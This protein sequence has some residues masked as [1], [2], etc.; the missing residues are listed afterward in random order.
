MNI[1]F[2]PYPKL[3]AS[4]KKEVDA[5]MRDTLRGG[6]FILGKEV[7]EF[8]KNFAEYLGVKHVVGLNS[9]TDA[10]LLALH[11]AGVG[12]GDEVITVSHTFIATIQVIKHVGATPI[13]VDIEDDGLMD[14]DLVGAAI[15]EKTKA[16]IPVHLSGDVVESPVIHAH[17]ASHKR[18]HDI[19]VIE[20]AA[21]A[22]GAVYTVQGSLTANKSGTIGDAGCFSFYPAKILGTF[23]DAG[24][25][26]T[27]D[28]AVA[29]E[30]RKLRNH[31]DISKKPLDSV[32]GPYKFGWN[33]RMDN[34]WAAVLN[35]KLPHLEEDIARR[36]VVASM[37]TLGLNDLPLEL[38]VMR[39]G[40]V[41]QDYVI[42]SEMRDELA[43]Y[44]KDK[45]IGILGHDL[46]PNHKYPGLGL[47][48]FH[49][50]KTEQYIA[51]QIRIP[52]NQFMK[53]KE[54]EY[55]IKTI[56]RFHGM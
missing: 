25:L 18:T 36:H 9:G 23:G 37:Y 24:A 17:L 3:Y 38:P 1:P 8:E 42:R 45:G 53:D 27:N 13:L 4:Y 26:A 47:D 56:R 34:V 7:E 48:H 11:A 10:L 29:E 50:P 49:L 22:I 2:L 16:I 20:D 28:D 14:V 31:Y 55:V 40:R 32:V 12:P 21:Q 6:R 41:F 19:K 30:V 33:S 35:A 5:A 39:E 52:C 15:T 54:V 51:Q 44:L 43:A 46:L